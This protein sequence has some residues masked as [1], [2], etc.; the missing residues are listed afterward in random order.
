MQPGASGPSR[1]DHSGST[2]RFHH[3]PQDI[4]RLRIQ[5]RRT[6]HQD[7]V[8]ALTGSRGHRPPCFPEHPPGPIPRHRAADVPGAHEPDPGVLPRWPHIDQHAGRWPA[9]PSVQGPPELR[10]SAQSPGPGWALGNGGVSGH[11][12]SSRPGPGIRR[13]DSRAPWR[14]AGQ[15]CDGR[16]GSSSGD[17]TRVSSFASCCSVDRSVS[18]GLEFCPGDW[19]A[20]ARSSIPFAP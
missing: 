12:R 8:E 2:Q 17:E 9:G 11:V 6:C 18:R 19:W 16:S 20:G 4:V 5:D 1:R 3:L 7:H 14:D 15:G 10:A 13:T